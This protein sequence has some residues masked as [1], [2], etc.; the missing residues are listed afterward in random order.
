MKNKT[1]TVNR[2]QWE[3]IQR[4]LAALLHALDGGWSVIPGSGAHDA[5]KVVVEACSAKS[6]ES[7]DKEN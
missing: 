3:Q 2:D 7:D 6:E 5:L 4:V 1:V